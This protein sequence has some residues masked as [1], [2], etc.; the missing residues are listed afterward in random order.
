MHA[1]EAVS[2]LMKWSVMLYHL[3]DIDEAAETRM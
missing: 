2:A 3:S 1:G